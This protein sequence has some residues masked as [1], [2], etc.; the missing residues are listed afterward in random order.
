MPFHYTT[1][2]GIAIVLNPVP[3]LHW[4]VPLPS[5]TG[6]GP[7][8]N[9]IYLLDVTLNI[10]QT[11]GHNK[12]DSWCSW[13]AC[14]P[15]TKH[16]HTH[17]LKC[18][19]QKSCIIWAILLLIHRMNSGDRACLSLKSWELDTLGLNPALCCLRL[20]F[21]IFSSCSLH[22]HHFSFCFSANIQHP[23]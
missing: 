19:F 12:D 20:E 3:L 13:K 11:D 10:V 15:L 6:W 9:S 18:S 8:T 16:Y 5:C 4:R 23:L 2:Q 7:V 14:F 21:S 17:S 22:P 1:H